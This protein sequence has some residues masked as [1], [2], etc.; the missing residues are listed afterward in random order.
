VRKTLPILVLTSIF[1]VGC[2]L[3]GDITPPPGMATRQAIPITTSPTATPVSTALP[4]LLT[5]PR[6]G[7]NPQKGKAL[8]TEKCSP[9]HGV[10][11]DGSGPQAVNLPEGINPPALN[12][13]DVTVME[14]D[15]RQ[16]ICLKE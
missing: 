15:P 7:A 4:I 12:D 11:G 14:A 9:C 6:S 2:N 8:Y 13:P 10:D 5:P 3:A 16:L 1:I